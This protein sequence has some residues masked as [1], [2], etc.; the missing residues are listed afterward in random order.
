MRSASSPMLCC[1]NI[2]PTLPP[3]ARNFSQMRGPSQSTALC[4]QKRTLVR[5]LKKRPL[6]TMPCCWGAAPVRKLAWAVQVS[7]G[8]VACAGRN[9][10]GRCL[11]RFQPKAAISTTR[12]FFGA[13]N[14]VFYGRGRIEKHENGKW[15]AIGAMTK[16]LAKKREEGIWNGGGLKRRDAEA[17][18]NLPRGRG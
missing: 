10:S 7:A 3:R 4:S 16:I 9:S 15:P 13:V 14:G 8:Q 11:T 2:M 6:A 18:R 12:S 1:Q 17:H 5:S